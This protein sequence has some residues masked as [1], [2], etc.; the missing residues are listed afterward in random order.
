MSCSSRCVKT[1]SK[2][3]AGNSSAPRTLC[4]RSLPPWA[5]Q[6]RPTRIRLTFLLLSV[7]RRSISGG[8]SC[9]MIRSRRPVQ[10][11]DG[12]H[13]RGRRAGGVRTKGAQVKA[14][15]HG[16]RPRGSG[17]EEHYSCCLHESCTWWH[18]IHTKWCLLCFRYVFT[19]QWTGSGKQL[20]YGNEMVKTGRLE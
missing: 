5:F 15:D 1:C 17:G 16:V 20:E 14:R 13:H 10:T 4:H 6:S 8:H 19:S 2:T 9:R 7:T 11:K 18:N 12:C 3:S